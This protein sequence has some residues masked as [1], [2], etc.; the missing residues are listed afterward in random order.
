MINLIKNIIKDQYYAISLYSR[1][2]CGTLVLF[3]IA[4]YLSVHDYGLF[5]SY[6][7]IAIFC[8]MFANMEFANYILVSSKAHVK[9]VQLKISLFMLNAIFVL[10]LVIILSMICRLESHLLFILVVIR[11]FFDGIFFA[12]ILPYFQATRKFNTIANIN[13]FYSLGIATIAIVA[14]ILKLSLT[15]FLILN[16]ILG[17][18]N[19]IQCSYYVKINYLLVVNYFKRFLEKLDR[20]ILGF[21]GS[22]LTDYLYAQTS[23]LYVAIFLTKEEAALYFAAFTIANIPALISAAQLQKMLPE[24]INAKYIKTKECLIKNLKFIFSITG[25]ILF[26]IILFGK[27][28]LKLFYGQSYYENASLILIIYFIANMLII[29][30]AVFGVHITANGYQNKKVQMKLE[31]ACITILSLFILHTFGIYG[32]IYSLLIASIYVSIRFTVLSLSI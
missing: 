22:T 32:A 20:S 9:E 27:F 23:S 15:K 1:Q 24:L 30:G 11:T 18:I 17:L 19:F 6:K 8:L 25:A 31:T 26:F 29:N 14:Y 12:L 3:I 16:I 4:H 2:I 13:I 7:N 5:T 10:F 28:V 21:I